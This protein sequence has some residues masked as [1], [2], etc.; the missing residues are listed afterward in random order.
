LFYRNDTIETKVKQEILSVKTKFKAIFSLLLVICFLVSLTAC[1]PDPIFNI[2]NGFDQ[3]V[4]VYFDEQKMSTINPKESKIFYPNE[5]LT[6]TNTDLLV[7]LK[8]DSGTVLYSKNFT[9][10]ELSSVL[11]SVHGTPY[12]I[13]NSK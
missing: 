11:E 8:G 7:E 13:G 9:W 2:G 6:K 12:W 1:H 4:T 3:P 10:D 5:I